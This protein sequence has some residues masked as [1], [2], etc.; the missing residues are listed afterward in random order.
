MEYK[1]PNKYIPIIYLLYSGGSRFGV[2][3][4][5][6]FKVVRDPRPRKA[7]GVQACLQNCKAG[8]FKVSGFGKLKMSRVATF[9]SLQWGPWEG[10]PQASQLPRDPLGRSG[11]V[12][13]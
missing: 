2:P 9:A 10:F 6:P 13:K 5:V 1:D 4:R 3:S 12:S 11:R 7:Y 8:R